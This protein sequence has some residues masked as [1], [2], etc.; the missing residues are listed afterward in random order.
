MVMNR[1]LFMTLSATGLATRTW[2]AV[3]RALPVLPA[4]KARIKA[5]AFDAFPIFDP[6]PVFAL[7][8]ELFPGTGLS[9][10]WRTRQFEYTWLRVAAHHYADFWQVTG[11]PL[12]FATTKLKLRLRPDDRSRLMNA[13]LA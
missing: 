2:L 11:E 7:A 1:R 6:R 3:P 9:D 8:E 4:T 12:L 13:Y 10:E 5:V